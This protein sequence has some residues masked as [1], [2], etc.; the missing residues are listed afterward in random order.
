MGAKTTNSLQKYIL[1]IQKHTEDEI[2][3][4]FNEWIEEKPTI[5]V[6]RIFQLI[7]QKMKEE[8]DK[9]SEI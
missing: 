7:S 1:E 4:N 8:F 3:V 2:I 5:P 6:N 9:V